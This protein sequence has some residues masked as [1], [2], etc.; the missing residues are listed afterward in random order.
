MKQ[1]RTYDNLVFGSQ[2]VLETIKSRKPIDKILIQKN[3]RNEQ[4]RE[5]IK[6]AGT[7]Q[8][9]VQQV[10]PEKIERVT[11]KNHQGVIAFVSAVEFSSTEGLVQMAWDEGKEPF[12]LI[13]DRVTD[14]R[15]FG[16][17][18]RTA[19][20]AGVTGII[21]PDK[22]SAAIN[23]D[24]VKTSSGALNHIPLCRESNLKET[25]L[26]LKESGLK[27]IACTE[28]TDQE[29]YDVDLTG[30]MAVIMGSEEDGISPEYL[31]LCD[32]RAKIPLKGKVGSLNV[33]VATGIILFETLR[34]KG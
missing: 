9:P 2:S 3:T 4:I 30:P 13:L 21:I 26:Y 34:Q 16:A 7:Y 17:I 11:Q 22:G 25:I 27:I 29:I 23:S 12:F 6:L 31:K 10:P 33:G 1:N 28:K 14:V 20:C 32:T 19:E 5:I 15:N 18:A 8:I 24:A